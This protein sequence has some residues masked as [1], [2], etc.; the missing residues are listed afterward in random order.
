DARSRWR[1][2]RGTPC[3]TPI[4]A[5]RT[6]T[7]PGRWPT[8]SSRR[9]LRSAWGEPTRLLRWHAKGAVEADDL[10][11]EVV[12]LADVQDEGGEV[13]GAAQTLGERDP[14]GQG[15]AALLGQLA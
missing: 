6:A 8:P 9:P 14:G 12:V 4:R 5:T 3:R 13:V 10:T 11:V 1:P 7:C 2:S 15:L